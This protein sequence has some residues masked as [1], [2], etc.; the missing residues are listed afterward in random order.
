MWVESN[1]EHHHGV[2][3]PHEG[4]ENQVT[5]AIVRSLSSVSQG[6]KEFC[7]SFCFVCVVCVKCFLVCC[8]VKVR[9]C[10]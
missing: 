4:F 2:D 5:E 1:V 10:K 7:L 6:I 9:S 3:S 8:V